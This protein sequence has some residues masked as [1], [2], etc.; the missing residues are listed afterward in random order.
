MNKLDSGAYITTNYLIAIVEKFAIARETGAERANLCLKM[1]Q[2]FKRLRTLIE[3]PDL[4]KIDQVKGEYK[5]KKR[6]IP[7]QDDLLLLAVKLSNHKEY[8]WPNA[9]KIVFGCRPSEALS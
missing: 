8:G 7:D 9:A 2:Y 4:A 5:S 6:T 1:N 3:L